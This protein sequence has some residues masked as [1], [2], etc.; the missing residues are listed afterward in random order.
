MYKKTTS[1]DGKYID[2]VRE[3]YNNGEAVVASYLP[4]FVSYAVWKAG[5]KPSLMDWGDATFHIMSWLAVFIVEILCWTHVESYKGSV[6]AE[7]AMYST[8]NPYTMGALILTVIS[9]SVVVLVIVFHVLSGFLVEGPLDSMYSALILG[10]MKASFVMTLVATLTQA[11]FT[12]DE[13]F[14]IYTMILLSGK[15]LVL[16]L[17]DSNLQLSGSGADRIKK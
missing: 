16:S 4:P 5:N 14:R 15:V 1:T 2:Q 6:A 17:L 9:F 11:A 8:L 13:K 10:G 7:Q 3:M 12:A